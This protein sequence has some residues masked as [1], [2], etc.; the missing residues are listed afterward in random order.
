[1]TGNV[2]IYYEDAC[3]A[4]EG[5]VAE[6]QTDENALQIFPNP[7]SDHITL[8]LS[9][10]TTKATIK[11]YN[12]LGELKYTSTMSSP[13]TTVDIADLAKG[14]YIIEVATEKNVM[15]EKFVKE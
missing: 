14:V 3:V 4:F 15:R 2:S 6:N 9:Q 8:K 7:S 11:I 1:V 12:L 10:N 13:E 5:G